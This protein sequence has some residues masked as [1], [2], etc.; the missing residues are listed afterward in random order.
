MKTLSS[1]KEEQKSLNGGDYG[2]L[3]KTVNDKLIAN[4]FGENLKTLDVTLTENPY[5]HTACNK[6][7]AKLEKHKCVFV[8][9]NSGDIMWKIHA[10]FP[11]IYAIN[12]LGKSVY[13]TTVKNLIDSL[14]SKDDSSKKLELRHQLSVFTGILYPD[15]RLNSMG[16]S[17]EYMFEDSI[18]N[19]SPGRKM[20]FTAYNYFGNRENAINDSTHRLRTYYS[21]KLEDIFKRNVELLY[22]DTASEVRNSWLSGDED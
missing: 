19:S 15:P 3:F 12:D 8:L 13:R 2:E 9:C 14:L 16:P 17:V 18:C 5:F 10:Y 20:L 6:I 22:I 21:P 4:G 1:V 11:V 7:N